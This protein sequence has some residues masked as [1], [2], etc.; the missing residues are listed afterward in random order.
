MSY[1]S[2]K[3]INEALYSVLLLK[4]EVYYFKYFSLIFELK[5][6]VGLLKVRFFKHLK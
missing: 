2:L 3:I 5:S 6:S 4:V 1:V